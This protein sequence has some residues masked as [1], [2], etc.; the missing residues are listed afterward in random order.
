MFR[1]SE[2][3]LPSL[4]D[5]NIEPIAWPHTSK[6]VRLNTLGR[7]VAPATPLHTNTSN[8]GFESFKEPTC[9]ADPPASSSYASPTPNLDGVFPA[10]SMHH[11][12]WHLTLD[13]VP[14]ES[15]TKHTQRISQGCSQ[16]ENASFSKRQSSRIR[17]CAIS[18][19]LRLTRLELGLAAFSDG[20][21]T[22]LSTLAPLFSAS[23]LSA[24]RTR[25]FIRRLISIK[26][27][28][29]STSA[30]VESVTT[31]H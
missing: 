5:F 8:G 18:H 21:S 11:A 13:N 26:P 24:P 27:Y 15:L 10:I 19:L 25:W 29:N 30:F 7:T 12:L 1:A 28:A 4:V 17:I 23:A 6:I 20:S 31:F 22:P 9:V 2:P 14:I 16:L 3:Q